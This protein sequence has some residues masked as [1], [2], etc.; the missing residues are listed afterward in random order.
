MNITRHKNCYC[1]TCNKY[2]HYMGISRH[3]ARHR[4]KKED[5]KIRFTNGDCYIWKYS[6]KEIKNEV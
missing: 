1:H 3:R 6:Q 2:F 5:C 4:D